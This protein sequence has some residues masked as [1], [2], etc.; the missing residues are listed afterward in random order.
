MGR[1]EPGRQGVSRQRNQGGRGALAH[2]ILLYTVLDP[3]T[4][5]QCGDPKQGLRLLLITCPTWDMFLSSSGSVSLPEKWGLEQPSY[6]M[7]SL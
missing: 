7:G 2:A 1:G 6:L 3:I 4:P 5:C